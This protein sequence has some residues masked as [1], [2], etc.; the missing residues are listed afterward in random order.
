MNIWGRGSQRQLETVDPRLKSL[1]NRV[2][3]HRDISVIQGHRGKTEQEEFFQKGVSKV[4]WPDSRHNTYPSL[5]VDVQPAPYNE[6]TLREDLSYIAGLFIGIGAT[7]GLDIRWGGDWNENGET[8][9]NSFDDLFHFELRDNTPQP[10]GRD[11]RSHTGGLRYN[12]GADPS[13]K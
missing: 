4:R 12:P 6:K 1:C 3:A 8:A 9:D 5:A 10:N 7:M 13:S 2:L 11:L